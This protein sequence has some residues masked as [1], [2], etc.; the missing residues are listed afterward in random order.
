MWTNVID[1]KT[2]FVHKKTMAERRSDSYP[3]KNC[4]MRHTRLIK[5]LQITDGTNEVKP[6]QYKDK[7]GYRLKSDS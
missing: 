3:N 2:D 6:V 7:N 5:R 4:T 1:G